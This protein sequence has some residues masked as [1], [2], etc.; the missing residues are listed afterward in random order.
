[1]RTSDVPE[2]S[3][4]E[5]AQQLRAEVDSRIRNQPYYG[6]KGGH[7]LLTYLTAEYLRRHGD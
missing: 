5:L 1:M 3:D 7:A 2:L 6:I 4:E